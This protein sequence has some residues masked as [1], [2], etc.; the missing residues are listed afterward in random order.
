M[1]IWAASATIE[2]HRHGVVGR[3]ILIDVAWQ[4]WLLVRHD[5]LEPVPLGG[6]PSARASRP[7]SS[8]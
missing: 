5:A 8:L 6:R 4:L 3:L 1:P 2:H 7:A